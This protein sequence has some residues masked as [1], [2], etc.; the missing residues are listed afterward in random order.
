MTG[1]AVRSKYDMVI[2]ENA[3]E[4]LK[5]ESFLEKSYQSQAE[6]LCCTT[7]RGWLSMNWVPDAW[8]WRDEMD[9]RSVLKTQRVVGLVEGEAVDEEEEEQGQQQL[10]HRL[11][12]ADDN[13]GDE[14]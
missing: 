2:C 4:Q 14:G 8:C 10:W 7:V 6:N 5:S 12:G 9:S 3:G 13:L 11:T 1:E